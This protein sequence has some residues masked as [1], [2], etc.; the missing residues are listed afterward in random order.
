MLAGLSAVGLVLKRSLPLSPTPGATPPVEEE[1]AAAAA[2]APR[3]R[4][5]RCLWG[6]TD[7]GGE[8]PASDPLSA[9]ELLL[10]A[11]TPRGPGTSTGAN[12]ALPPPARRDIA[13]LPVVDVLT[14]GAG[15]ISALGPLGGL[16]GA[17]TPGVGPE[18][19]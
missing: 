5:L 6:S 16:K 19:A 3:P 1:D 12:P 11:G 7:A 10:V 2:A 14:G 9:V 17:A 15:V 18:G 4:M 8:P 13:L